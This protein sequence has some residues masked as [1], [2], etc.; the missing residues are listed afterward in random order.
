VQIRGAFWSEHDV[1]VGA[2]SDQALLEIGFISAMQS[3]MTV[4]EGS[5]RVLA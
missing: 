4:L 1:I 5:R 3:E 2:D